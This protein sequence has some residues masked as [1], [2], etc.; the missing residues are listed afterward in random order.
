MFPATNHSRIRS[1][2]TTSCH[3]NVSFYF[4]QIDCIDQLPELAEIAPMRFQHQPRQMP[5]F[6]LILFLGQRIALNDLT[7]SHQMSELLI[8]PGDR[9]TR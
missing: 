5:D 9:L 2:L 8:E 3:R 1:G 6:R 4:G 7:F